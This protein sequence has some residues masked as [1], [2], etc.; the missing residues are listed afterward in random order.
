MAWAQHG[1][2]RWRDAIEVLRLHGN[3][4]EFTGADA[5][6]DRIGYLAQAFKLLLAPGAADHEQ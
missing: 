2:Q 1:S 6:I 5:F 3:D 4:H